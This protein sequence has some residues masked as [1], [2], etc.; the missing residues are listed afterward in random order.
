LTDGPDAMR[1]RIELPDTTAGRD[2]A[3]LVRSRVL[4]GFSVEFRAIEEDWQGTHRTVLRARMTGIGVVHRPAYSGAVLVE[5][6]SIDTADW[7]ATRGGLLRKVR[8]WRS[9]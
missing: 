8:R 9:L 5:G 1:A 7:M 3:Q 2:A 4:R 6:R